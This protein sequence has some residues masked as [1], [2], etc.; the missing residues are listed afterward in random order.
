MIKIKERP[1]S[2]SSHPDA[3]FFGDT[4]ILFKAPNGAGLSAILPN[5][6]EK[7]A[8]AP[9]DASA[10]LPLD[11]SS[12][13]AV[14]VLETRNLRKEY[15]SDDLIVPALRGIDMRARKGEFLAIMGPSGSGKSTLLHILG[16]VEIPTSGQ[17]LLEG[18]DLATLDDDRR[19]I[20]RR[21][22]MGFIFQSFNLLPAFTAEENVTL[23][24]ELGGVPSSEAR[25]RALE[26]LDLVGMGHRRAHIPSNLSGGE[27]QRVAI[28]RALVVQPA[29]LLADEPTGNLDS[30]NGQQVTTLLR[31]LVDVQ[32]QTIV[33]VTHDQGV[34]DQADRL[35]RLR[36]GL[37]ESD[38]QQGSGS[39]NP[40]R[41]CLFK[42]KP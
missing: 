10:D 23:P 24:L 32:H 6:V 5:D 19:T 31:R 34:A 28:A 35:I 27:Q 3:P 36:D 14:Y 12:E 21:T 22:R 8:V 17:V 37:I 38:G 9:N 4:T 16:G 1:T 40:S 39:S 42:R 30:I 7:L 2:P 25:R 33:M 15:G 11:E 18:R 20:L 26:T 13:T 29:L 41:S